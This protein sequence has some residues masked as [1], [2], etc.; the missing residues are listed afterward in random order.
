MDPCGT[1]S[2]RRHFPA[3]GQEHAT[4]DTPAQATPRSRVAVPQGVPR[5]RTCL[6]RKRGIPFTHAD[7]PRLEAYR[8]TPVPVACLLFLYTA[9]PTSRPQPKPLLQLLLGR[10]RN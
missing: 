4:A 7:H 1:N 8:L 10:E 5:G 6:Q 2:A 3:G 9:L